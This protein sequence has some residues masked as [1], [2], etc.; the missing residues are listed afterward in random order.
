MQRRLAVAVGGEVH[1]R[2]RRR[3]AR[4]SCRPRRCATSAAGPANSG[5]SPVT[6]SMI[7]EPVVHQ[8]DAADHGVAGAVRAAMGQRVGQRA[9]RGGVGRRRAGREDRPAMPHIRASPRSPRNSPPA[10]HHGRLGVLRLVARRGRRAA[11]A[12]AHV[13]LVQHG[14]RSRRRGAPGPPAAP[15][16]RSRPA[17]IS[18][19]GPCGG[20][21]HHRAAGGP[22]LDHHVAQRLVPAR[23]RPARRAAA[24]SAAGIAAPAG[25]VQPVGD[26]ARARAS[27]SSAAAPAPRRRSRRA[28]RAAAAGRGSGRRSPC[29]GAA[30]RARAATRRR[31][32]AP[33][34]AGAALARSA[35]K[36]GR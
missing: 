17:S 3:A 11:R 6:R 33:S 8:R 36:F 28:R 15:A 24:S 1:V 16:G 18:S 21:G 31:A 4:G 35:A 30:G 7:G 26:A 32:A 27:S 12:A 23:G 13:R 20:G 14:W 19:R 2:H 9:Q 5:W 34:A 29:C 22:G 25:Q 10:R